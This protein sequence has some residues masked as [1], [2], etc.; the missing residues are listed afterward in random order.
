MLIK[1]INLNKKKFFSYLIIK[2]NNIY[3]KNKY[4]KLFLSGNGCYGLK[5][6]YIFIYNLKVKVLIIKKNKYYL[7]IDFFSFL[8]FI[9]S[10]IKFNFLI[11]FKKLFIINIKNFSIFKKCNCNLSFL[12]K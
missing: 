2:K 9:N 11:K 6:N 8:Y 10:K 4:L 7:T 3:F 12:Y 1:I 5:Y